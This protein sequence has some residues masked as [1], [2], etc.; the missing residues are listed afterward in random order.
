M[1]LT[2]PEVKEF[3]RLLNGLLLYVNGK[4]GLFPKI[5][6]EASLVA[7]GGPTQFK[8]G[9]T[10]YEDPRH[11]T[12][13]I[14]K[15]P[16]GLSKEELDTVQSW[17]CFVR[18]KFMVYRYTEEN[19]VFIYMESKPNPK[20]YGVMSLNTPLP[21]MLGLGLPKMVETTLLPFRGRIVHDGQIVEQ[22]LVFG[23]GMRTAVDGWYKQALSE[24]GLIIDLLEPKTT[25][26]RT[27]KHKIAASKYERRS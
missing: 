7:A 16:N 15:N 14:Q 19:T 1:Q 25:A 10:V 26:L 20:A 9:N 11:I 4:T 27:N 2:Q 18:G 22:P 13:Y 3:F 5:K 8:L 21:M 24:E 12:K 17:R 23:S 6:D